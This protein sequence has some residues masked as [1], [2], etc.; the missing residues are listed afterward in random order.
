ML[1]VLRT[2]RSSRFQFDRMHRR[3]L[4][5]SAVTTTVLVFGC[6]GGAGHSSLSAR[7]RQGDAS[8]SDSGI[9]QFDSSTADTGETETLTAAPDASSPANGAAETTRDAAAPSSPVPPDP[10][11]SPNADPKPAG[12]STA[13]AGGMNASDAGG[14]DSKPEGGTP[15]VDVP[16]TDGCPTDAP[17]SFDRVRILPATGQAAQL[18]GARI[19]GSNSGPTTNFVDLATIAQAPVEGTFTELTFENSRLYRY[20]R[21]YAGPGTLGGLAEVEFFHGASRLSGDAFGT[22]SGDAQQPF[23]FALD[24]DPATYFAGAANGGRYVGLDIARGYVTAPVSFAPDGATAA[25]P[26]DVTLT[27][28]TPGA[29]IRY[30]VDGSDPTAGVS[31]TYSEPLRVERGTTSLRAVAQS[32]C[33]FDSSIGSAT[34]SIGQS[35]VPVGSG[36]RS[37]HIGNSLTDTINPWLEPIADSTGVDHVYARWTIPG[38]PIRWLA[39]HQGQGF[40]DPAGA[41]HFDT[42]VQTFSPIDHLSIQPYSDPDF[43]SQGGAAVGFLTTALQYNPDIQFWIYAQWPGQ[44]AWA[45]E[46]FANG[47][48]TVYPDWQ[49]ARAPTNWEE[50]AQNYVL[51]FEAFR[52]YVDSRV[53]GKPLLIVP[54]GLALVELKRQIDAGMVPGFVDFF[55]AMFEDE[56][57]LKTPAQYLIAL[58]FY[59]CLYRQSPEARVT[60]AGTGLTSEQ[61]LI[62]QRIAW[63]VASSY[64]GSGIAP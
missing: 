20:L 12:D 11:P 9:S 64:P 13:T 58:V 39:E 6:Q 22:A 42:F 30:T 54:G 32:A 21:F 56:A 52:D 7:A 48:G 31:P 40:E 33:R 34:Y 44:T 37:Y 46:S 24:G 28:A 16:R 10:S 25:D 14:I 45:T 18:V 36:L 50:G 53:G 51:Y 41:S 57:H 19:Q 4:A 62:F 60:F 49:V 26:I 47:G 55:G 63:D 29:V 23:A 15:V 43:E 17:Q 61:A 38:A 27:S 59:A 1:N 3:A 8:A 2:R 5:W 35:T